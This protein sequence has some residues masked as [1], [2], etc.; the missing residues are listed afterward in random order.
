MLFLCAK[1]KK[2]KTILI[3]A[4]ISDNSYSSYKRF[5]WFYKHIF[6]NIDKIFAQSI[7]DKNRLES[8]GARNIEVIG[9]I[10]LTQ[11]PKIT[12]LFKKTDDFFITAASTHKKEEK[13][14]LESYTKDYG[15]LIIVPRH[16][17]RFN[18]V[19]L[20]I[21]KFIQN[22]DISYHRYSNQNNFNS[23]IIL[24]DIMGELNNLFSI[25]DAVILFVTFKL[26]NG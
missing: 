22:K 23:N 19:D 8:L 24:F 5:S 6:N 20:L 17:E 9:N 21:K 12:K 11:L 13:L 4:R 25:S 1:I 7:E 26:V 16:Q 3:N 15:K 14:I 2:T 10:K 18:N